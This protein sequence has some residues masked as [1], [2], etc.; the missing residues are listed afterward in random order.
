MRTSA[1]STPIGIS[2]RIFSSNTQLS[3][4]GNT[5]QN[6][7]ITGTIPANSIGLNGSLHITA[8]LTWTSSANAKTF[9]IL[10]NGTQ[11]AATALT[12]SSI[13]SVYTIIRNRNSMNIQVSGNSSS[14]SNMGFLTA[15][16][17]AVGTYTFNMAA[18]LPFTVTLQNV[19]GADT[20]SIEAFEII[21]YY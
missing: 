2:K 4:T 18:D 1:S 15:G 9:R 8:L 14:N 17:A 19:D 20:V 5:T 16:S 10:F 12:T 7:I 13:E 6:T 3:N 21:G 11:I